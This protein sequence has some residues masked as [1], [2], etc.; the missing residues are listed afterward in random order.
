VKRQLIEGYLIGIVVFLFVGN[1]FA[2]GPDTI[3]TKVY[4]TAV[5]DW[6]K[7]IQQTSDNGFIIVGDTQ[8]LIPLWHYDAYLI[9][10]DAFG[11]TLWTKTY[12]GTNH[13][14]GGSVQVTSDGG[15]IIAGST[16]SFGAGNGDF[17]LIKTNADGDT[18]WT[19][20]YGGIS[21]EVA[22][23]SQVT[24]D[25]GFII[26]GSTDS[27]G[28]GGTDVYLV[29]TD[30]FGDTLWTRTYGGTRTDDGWSVQQTSDGGY[31][32]GGRTW[33]FGAGDNDFYLIKTDAN[34]DAIW[35]RTYGGSGMDQGFSVQQTSDGGYIATGE[36][37]SFGAGGTDV[38]L[39]RTD[40]AGD[41]LWTRTY[42]GIEYDFGWSVQQT[43]Y[44]GF[45]IAGSS[46][47]FGAGGLD[48]YL[49]RTDALGDT[50]WTKTYG[51][52]S[53][54]YGVSVQL[55]SDGG[56]I[57]AGKT[58]SFGSG[59]TDFY[60]VRLA[61]EYPRP[62]A[63]AGQNQMVILGTV[64]TLDGSDSYDPDEK[65]PLTYFWEITTKPMGSNAELSDPTIVNPSFIADMLGEYT[66]ELVVTD[67]WGAQSEFDVVFISTSNTP[68]IADA[69]DDQAVIENGTEVQL[70]GSQSYDD[71]GHDIIYLW[72]MIQKPLE[73]LAELSDNTSEKPSFISDIHGDY[74]IEL[75]VT[76]IFES[77]SDPDIVTISFE[78]VK[79]V[80]E[81]GG[82][83]SV[84]V[85]DTVF[86]DGD[87]SYDA[88][89]DPLTYNWSFVFKPEGSMA[90]FTNP[91][92]VW[93][94]FETDE[95]GTYIVSL[96][97]NDSF[98]DSDPSNAEI[99]VITSQEAAAL[100]LIDAINVINSLDPEHFKNKNLKKALTNKINAVLAMIDE[101][102]YE[103][104][105]DKLSNDILQKINGCADNGE[106]DKNDW[107]ITCEAQ[108]MV[109]PLIIEAMEYLEELL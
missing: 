109:Y 24:S 98:E 90:E 35:T 27:F 99:M 50:L 64:V 19:R 75:I 74:E 103:D 46:Y 32:V 34:G 63:D 80:A 26:A 100:T 86:L 53:N 15:F 33:S 2:Q 108:N 79:P 85:G 6:V 47:S 83:Q 20:T 57:V 61:H 96:V 81:V 70:D 13:D 65:Y 25:G 40:A 78:N 49:I 31:I 1:S 39:V 28:E 11:D 93:T 17:Y 42:G 43:F 14:N 54:D 51:G 101:G 9:K 59:S 23:S 29:R 45:I 92:S 73:S 66:I 68:P 88:N 104:A 72:T 94:D 69:G 95:P 71:E 48:L 58:E 105:L 12:G 52:T 62:I 38:Y 67:D 4:G 87:G 30:A 107:I 41:T 44:G 55:T 21:E 97:V 76:D 36:T 37:K 18:L 22:R 89:L 60:L 82:N 77:D 56:Y 3:W 84:I 8:S 106:P 16:W 7:D 10:I 5:G 102:R 91:T